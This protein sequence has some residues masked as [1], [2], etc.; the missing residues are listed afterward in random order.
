MS[1]LFKSTPVRKLL[2]HGN[3][4]IP[5]RLIR[6]MRDEFCPEFIDASKRLDP[7]KRAKIM[8]LVI[9]TSCL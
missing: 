8:T 9:V 3:E 1:S 2:F 7:P 4:A 5:L 6:F